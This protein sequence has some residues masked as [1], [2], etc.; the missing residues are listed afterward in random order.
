MNYTIRAP[1]LTPTVSSSLSTNRRCTLVVAS[2]RTTSSSPL[3]LSIEGV[4]SLPRTRIRPAHPAAVA[5]S[6]S[7]LSAELKTHQLFLPCLGDTTGVSRNTRM[8][9]P[10][11]VTAVVPVEN[12]CL[13]LVLSSCHQT[14]QKNT[15]LEVV[16]TQGARCYYADTL[17]S[18]PL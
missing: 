18:T 13:R 17:P 9:T 1:N 16:P 5:S 15:C 8:N 10:G 4:L 7:P 14:S 12:T 11:G 2:A 3:H 6:P